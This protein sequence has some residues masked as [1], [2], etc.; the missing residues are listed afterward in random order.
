VAGIIQATGLQTYIWNNN[1]RSALLLA[2]FP[3]LLIGM[4]WG[5][6][7]A[8][9]MLGGS[10]KSVG[11]ALEAATTDLVVSTPLALIVAGVW[12]VIA[13]FF[14]GIM[15]DLATGS[16]RVT[17]EEQPALYNALE[18]L[19]ISRGIPLPQLKIMDSDELNAF[20]SG[21]QEGRFSIS[22]TSGIMQALEPDELEAVLGHELTHVMNRDVRTMV[23]ASVFAGIITL[24]A[25][26]VARLLFS[27]IGWGGGR[28]RSR[29]GGGGG[30]TII[31]FVVAAA[32]AAIG[33]AL[34][35]VIRM[36]IS[37]QREFL[38][39]AGSVELTKN[40]DAMIRAL[41]KISGNAHLDAPESMRAMFLENDDRGVFGLFATHPPIEERIEALVRYAGGRVD[42]M[43]IG[44]DTAQISEPQVAMPTAPQ[45]PQ[46]PEPSQPQ[47]P[48]QPQGPWG[49]S[50][51]SEPQ[52]GPS[53]PPGRRG[54]W[55]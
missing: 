43:P 9:H 55:G 37:R 8:A 31:F 41:Q 48:A 39:D 10:V 42:L 15:I 6:D 13:Y 7:F 49:A 20:A 29:E 40:P 25:Q 46:T 27:G 26:V 35:I 53:D 2:G 14:N 51:P 50:P 38:A 52:Q 36:A 4:I 21:L 47:A 23:V 34:A 54:P 18:N 3:V 28:S 17:R 24:I 19:C 12:F 32:I 45:M 11:Y 30:G 44:Q 1:L 16:H 22:V 33:Y 5:L